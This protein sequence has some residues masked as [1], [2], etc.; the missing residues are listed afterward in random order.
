MY[1]SKLP[2]KN[3]SIAFYMK[4]PTEDCLFSSVS[5]G[6]TYWLI[7][8]LGYTNVPVFLDTNHSLWELTAIHVYQAG[9]NEHTADGDS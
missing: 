9:V 8:F 6:N 2:H 5:I 3:K 1:L 7:Q 4:N